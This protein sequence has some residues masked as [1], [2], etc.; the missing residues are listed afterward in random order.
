MKKIYCLFFFITVLGAAQACP[1]CGS[2]VGN[3][4][5]GILPEFKNSF[6]GVRYQHFRYHSQVAGEESE[7]GHDYYNTI[8]LWGGVSLGKRWQLLGYLPCQIN[9]R[10]TDDGIIRQNGLSDITLMANYKVLHGIKYGEKGR[11]TGQELWLGGGVKLPTGKYD[12]NLEDPEVNIGDANAQLGSGS[13]DVL[14][15]AMYNV[16]INKVGIN[17]T[18]NYKVNTRNTAGY[19]FGNRFSANSLVY[20]AIQGKKSAIAPNLGLMYQHLETNHINKV[21]LEE[22]GGYILLGSV[23]AELNFKKFVVGGNLQLPV[24]QNFAHGQTESGMRGMVHISFP[25]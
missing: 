24:S 20:Y 3:F 5:M 9:L 17:T 4:Y 7:F 11:S 6:M 18:L 22:T 8:E 15:N 10:R 21:A 16:R 23:G 25:L 12:V 13:T 19:D 14:L 1:F 2:G